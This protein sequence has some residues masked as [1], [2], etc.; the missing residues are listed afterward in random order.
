MREVNPVNGR[1]SIYIA[2]NDGMEFAGI[3]CTNY[4][5]AKFSIDIIEVIKAE[6]FQRSLYGRRQR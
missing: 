4:D 2:D 3:S 1:K 6:Y 5:F